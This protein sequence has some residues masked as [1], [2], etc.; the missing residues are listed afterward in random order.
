MLK[1]N[2][3]TNNET[4]PL[5]PFFTRNLHRTPINRRQWKPKHRPSKKLSPCG[6]L[7]SFF[8]R[9][10]ASFPIPHLK[11]NVRS[12]LAKLAKGTTS[13]L[14]Y[15]RP[16]KGERKSRDLKYSGIKE[17]RRQR[18]PSKPQTPAVRTFFR[19]T[20]S[21]L[22]PERKC[23]SGV[24]I[25]ASADGC[26]I[27][28]GAIVKILISR[29]TS[30][31]FVARFGAFAPP[32]PFGSGQGPHPFLRIDTRRKICAAV[33]SQR[34]SIVQICLIPYFSMI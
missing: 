17:C 20:V 33:S 23:A 14:N 18:R 31:A 22:N 27:P 34:R 29:M 2:L 6:P 30:I 9:E 3:K 1:N 11:R 16:M 15:V 7:C 8:P 12:L 13:L 10:V 24:S 5:H 21:G 32:V 19:Y 25:P 28:R 26:K 4:V